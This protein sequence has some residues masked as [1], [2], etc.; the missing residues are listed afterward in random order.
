MKLNKNLISAFIL[1]FIFALIASYLYKKGNSDHYKN[2]NR[3]IE[4][5]DSISVIGDQF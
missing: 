1:I 4:E 3:V 2:Y 5:P